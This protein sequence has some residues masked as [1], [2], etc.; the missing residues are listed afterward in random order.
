MTATTAPETLKVVL[1]GGGAQWS[2]W[3]G[4]V[5]TA[6]LVF[7]TWVY[8]RHTARMADQM[9]GQLEAMREQQGRLEEARLREK[10]DRG[11]YGCLDAVQQLL[12][13][14]AGRPPAAVSREAFQT[15]RI[16]LERYAPL[17][18]DR[19]VR[20]YVMTFREVAF[21]AA[22]GQEQTER[23]EINAGTLRLLAR[24]MAK[25]LTTVLHTYLAEQPLPANVWQHSGDD[26]HGS[27]YPDPGSVGSWVRRVAH[28]PADD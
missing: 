28:R 11:A 21:I 23:E 18:H 24:D 17:I 16:Q 22:F 9:D 13:E 27:E 26:G 20:D 2:D 19:E 7:V 6:A 3:I 1:E 10:S 15:A 5:L 14:Y 25:R 8:V 4:V 12:A